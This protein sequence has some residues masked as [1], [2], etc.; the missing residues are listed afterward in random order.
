MATPSRVNFVQAGQ[1]GSSGTTF[2]S[3]AQSVTAGNTL[4]ACIG[5]NAQGAQTVTGVTDTAGHTYT[6]VAH[7]FNTGDKF[8]QE[9]WVAASILTHAANVVT[10]TWS[11][12]LDFRGIVVMQYANLDPTT[13]LDDTEQNAAGLTTPTLTG[14][15][16]ESV[17][18]LM[19]RWGFGSTV[20]PAGFTE[21]TTAGAGVP[22]VADKVVTGGAFSGT[23][24]LTSANYFV[25]AVIF[26]TGAAAGGGGVDPL[27]WLL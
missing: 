5:G 7:V 4:V 21:F 10:A 20:F 14:T 18:V 3:P 27:P 16:P 15:T 25:L 1:D 24:T 9:V 19:T 26:K 22:E 6:K 2:A 23:Y 17:H 12:S 13:P 8:R 11:A